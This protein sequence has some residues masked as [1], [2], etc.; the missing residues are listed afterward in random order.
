MRRTTAIDGTVVVVCLPLD[1]LDGA[2][3]KILGFDALL[4]AVAVLLLIVVSR[5]VVRLGLRPLTRMERTARAI[6]GTGDLSVRIPDT[7]PA[8]EA[9]RLGGVLNSMLDRLQAALRDKRQG[10]GT[11]STTPATSCAPR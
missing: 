1:T 2:T 3:T 11:S 5:W 9:G 8:T 6:T 10:C 4:L 7:D